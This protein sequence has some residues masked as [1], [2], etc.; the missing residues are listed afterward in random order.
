MIKVS[1]EVANP[2][3]QAKMR[4]LLARDGRLHIPNFLDDAFARSL[5]SAFS[6]IDWTTTYRTS[7]GGMLGRARE[8]AALD[9]GARERMLAS[10]HHYAGEAFQYYFDTYRVSH[11]HERGL[12]QEGVLAEF[13]AGLNSEGAIA[14]FAAITGDARIRCLDA[15]ATRYTQGQFLLEHDDRDG[16]DARLFAYVLNL[17]PRWKPDWGGLLMF[18]DEQGQVQR[19]IAPRWNALNIFKVPQRHAVSFVTPFAKGARYSITGWMRTRP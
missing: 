7:E 2:D 13:C 1:A 10:I 4:L 6:D 16:E 14:L 12:L 8:L 11:L 3:L 19:A 15:Q 9:A 17:T 18:I 5:L